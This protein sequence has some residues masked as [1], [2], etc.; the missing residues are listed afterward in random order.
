VAF[1][2]VMT[3]RRVFE[4]C[5]DVFWWK[6][7]ADRHT[8]R[9]ATDSRRRAY[10]YAWSLKMLKIVPQYDRS[11]PIK[12]PFTGH[13]VGLGKFAK[14]SLQIPLAGVQVYWSAFIKLCLQFFLIEFNSQKVLK[15]LWLKTFK[16]FGL[17]LTFL[18]VLW[19]SRQARRRKPWIVLH[20]RQSK[21]FFLNQ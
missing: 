19:W 1:D 15:L 18:E 8:R 4:V 7:G 5:Q 12:P 11:Y 13:S 16:Y 17:F 2:N 6:R 20:C 3:V 21:S 9:V 14:L 10:V